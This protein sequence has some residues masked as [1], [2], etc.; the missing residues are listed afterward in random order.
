MKR[1]ILL[2]SALAVTELT[3]TA[4]LKT[5]NP[6][7]LDSVKGLTLRQCLEWTLKGNPEL[8]AL[9]HDVQAAEGLLR[10]A[11]TR[12]NPEL[13][14][15]A[16]NLAASGSQDGYD[17]A[18]ISVKLSQSL[19]LG[20]K[21]DKR[22]RVAQ[23]ESRVAELAYESKKVDVTAET[24]NAFVGV[25]LAQER[26]ALAESLLTVAVHVQN[27]AS[28]R[29]KAGKISPLEE[30]KAGVEASSARMDRDRA[31]LDLDTSRKHLS[32]FWGET[33]PSFSE[34]TGK[35]DVVPEI[36]TFDML[37]SLLNHS[38]GL[39]QSTEETEWGRRELALAE[40]ERYPDMEVSAGISRFEEDG[41]HA[42]ILGFSIPL[43]LFDR[44][45]GIVTAARHRALRLEDEQRATRARASRELIEAY[46]QLQ[47]A[48]AEALIIQKELLTGVQHAFQAAQTGYEEGKTGYL[49]VLDA[50]RTLGEAQ[51]RYLDVLAVF[52]KAAI[53]VERLTG[54]PLNTI[55]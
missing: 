44:K 55:Q 49:E 6:S 39:A 14:V 40:A 28:E 12:P 38:P 20:G 24:R 5:N 54:H 4:E 21:R 1:T 29:V 8:A 13:E 53:D 34:A 25:L 3:V 47:S 17:T 37:A 43:P 33:A 16:E 26:F 42:G 22:R 41:T 51:G 30:I 11:G 9:S 52:Q 15:E 23:S 18:E 27:M 50:Q 46:N 7:Q 2:I 36:P 19:E 10:Q 32:S 31:R 45:V 35:L 48:R